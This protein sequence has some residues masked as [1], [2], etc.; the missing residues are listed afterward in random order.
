MELRISSGYRLCYKAEVSG[1]V[2]LGPVHDKVKWIAVLLASID[3]N[4]FPLI[5]GVWQPPLGF[6]ELCD[7]P[8]CYLRLAS[9]VD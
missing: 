7:P 3:M 8:C 5:G 4:D 9:L 1:S 6:M 2:A